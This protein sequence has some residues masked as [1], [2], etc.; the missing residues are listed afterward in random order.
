MITVINKI[1]TIVA[2][3]LFV[4]YWSTTLF[5]VVLPEDGAAIALNYHSYK[6]FDQLLFQRWG[7]F[8]PPPNFDERLYFTFQN[9][10]DPLDKKTIE[11]FEKLHD[12]SRNKYP[13]NDDE[14]TLDY[15]IHNT[16]EAIS[17]YLRGKYE[18]YKYDSC[19]NS[20]TDACYVEF[21]N[22]EGN[23]FVNNSAGN[24]LVNYGKSIFK[25]LN[26]EGHYNLKITYCT[27]L[28]PKFSNRNESVQK[29]HENIIFDTNNYDLK[30]N[31]WLDY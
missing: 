6:K 11:V 17:T 3:T 9:T 24:T 5:F 14:I 4:C 16:A 27:V 10:N 12:N 29:R 1:K 13:L 21:I 23:E 7:F 18:T 30:Q 22:S 15:I 8:A 25:N 26:I 19:Q 31:K 20:D 28:L 2:L